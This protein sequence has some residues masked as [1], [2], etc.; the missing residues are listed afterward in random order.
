MLWNVIS[1]MCTELPIIKHKHKCNQDVLHFSVFSHCLKSVDFCF[2]LDFA[3]QNIEFKEK[4]IKVK[5]SDIHCLCVLV[6][7]SICACNIG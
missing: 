6:F 4:D 1:L 3:A 5:I 7:V 2:L